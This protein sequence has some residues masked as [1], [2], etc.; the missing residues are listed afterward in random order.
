M[1]QANV[2]FLALPLKVALAL[3]L[4]AATLAFA[5][6]LIGRLFQDAFARLPAVFGA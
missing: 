3:I 1:P 2:Y 4:L 5:P 6:V